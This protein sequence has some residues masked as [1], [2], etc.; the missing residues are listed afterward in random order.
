MVWSIAIG[1]MMGVLLST[2]IS[3]SLCNKSQFPA[4]NSLDELT[5]NDYACMDGVRDYGFPFKYQI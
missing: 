5:F 3:Y 4:A 1:G 2:Y